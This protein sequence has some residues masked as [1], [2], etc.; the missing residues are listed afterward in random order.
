MLLTR[1]LINL[2]LET[3]PNVGTRTFPS[4]IGYARFDDGFSVIHHS[5]KADSESRFALECPCTECEHSTTG[6]KRLGKTSRRE[7]A[8]YACI[9]V[10][11]QIAKIHLDAHKLRVRIGIGSLHRAVQTIV[12]LLYIDSVR[13]SHTCGHILQPCWRSARIERDG[14]AA[15]IILNRVVGHLLDLVELGAVHRI[16]RARVDRAGAHVLNDIAAH[17]HARVRAD[18]QA[19]IGGHHA[20][21]RRAVGHPNLQFIAIE[22]H[23]RVGP[24]GNVQSPVR[25]NVRGW[26]AIGLNVPTGTGCLANRLQGV[27][28]V[29]VC[30]AGNIQVRCYCAGRRVVSGAPAQAIR[31]A[32]TQIVDVVLHRGDAAFDSSDPIV[33]VGDISLNVCHPIFDLSGPVLY[34]SDPSIEVCH[35]SFDIGHTP[36]KVADG[37]IGI[38]R[39]L[40]ELRDVDRVSRRG[41]GC[42]VGQLAFCTG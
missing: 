14:T 40:I 37:I 21:E 6:L 42:D 1:N 13:W 28:D 11:A 33:E 17:V 7:R 16:R 27:I 34:R 10:A 26:T 8:G 38:L 25:R 36:I 32:L 5:R 31:N 23:D 3:K 29:V 35:V 30:V 24:C 9:S 19:A 41:T 18:R 2:E 39:D 4:V 20:S 12:E 15:L 22:R